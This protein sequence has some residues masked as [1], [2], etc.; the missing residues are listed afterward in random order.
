MMHLR[1][2]I[3]D[4]ICQNL[5]PVAVRHDGIVTPMRTTAVPQEDFP[6]F[7]VLYTSDQSSPDGV[8]Y[9][10]VTGNELPRL[11]H[12]L[13]VNVVI[14]FKGRKDPSREFDNLAQD[15]ER[16]LP[17]SRLDGLIIDMILSSTDH[18]IDAGT[19]QSL[20]AGRMV[21]EITYRTFAGHPERAA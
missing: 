8:V 19:A 4:K 11:N 10:A 20:G 6:C 3:L 5:R 12:R 21:F 15:V 14:H 1:Q 2:Q 18:F 7:T 17:P 9:D 16:A 13:I